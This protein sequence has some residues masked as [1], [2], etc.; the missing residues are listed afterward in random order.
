M[1]YI[2][3]ILKQVST[4]KHVVSVLICFSCRRTIE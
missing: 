1:E 3:K 4:G 2:E